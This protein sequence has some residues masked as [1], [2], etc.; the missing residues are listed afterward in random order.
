M[1][2]KRSGLQAH[3]VDEREQGENSSI[4]AIHIKIHKLKCTVH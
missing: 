3:V 2:D 1:Q 4:N